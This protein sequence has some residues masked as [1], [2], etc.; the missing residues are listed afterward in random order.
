MKNDAFKRE[1][2]STA[3][4]TVYENRWMRVREDRIVRSSGANGVYGVVEKKD[5]VLIAAYQEGEL[6]LVEQY[7]YP[8]EARFWE[9]PQGASHQDH[10][11]ATDL[12]AAELRE[13]TGLVAASIV[14]AGRLYPAYGFATQAFDI[15][16]ATNLS[17]VGARSKRR[18]R[19]SRQGLLPRVPIV[20][21]HMRG[22]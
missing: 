10:I 21:L 11:A 3:S 4:S 16:L 2:R 17:Y 13:E 6:H 5:F 8:V 1:I 14:H 20:R 19:V 22:S 15:Y 9:F 7:R 18:R 12:A